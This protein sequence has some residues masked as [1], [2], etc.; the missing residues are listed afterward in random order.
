[1][2]SYTENNKFIFENNRFSEMV[3]NMPSRWRATLRVTEELPVS[4][5]D[6][7]GWLKAEV[8]EE[9]AVAP[10]EVGMLRGQEGSFPA[11]CEL[12]SMPHI[13]YQAEGAPG[14]SQSYFGCF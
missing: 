12:C 7:P 14:H 9:P 10:P 4:L 5:G 13:S 1:M 3:E 2:R 11:V 8:W 6:G